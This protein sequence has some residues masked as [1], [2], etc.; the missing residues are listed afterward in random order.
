MNAV[1]SSM[2]LKSLETVLVST[3][4]L[5][6]SPRKKLPRKRK[7]QRRP[8][9]K[10]RRRQMGTEGREPLLSC[11]TLSLADAVCAVGVHM[12]VMDRNYHFNLVWYCDVLFLLRSWKP[13][14]V[15]GSDSETRFRASRLV[16]ILYLMPEEISDYPGLVWEHEGALT[17]LLLILKWQ[18]RISLFIRSAYP[19]L[20]YT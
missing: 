2:P 11:Y 5:M 15:A 12:Y 9:R 13:I 4:K 1:S 14:A 17:R 19:I 18:G 16:T 8:R 7:R 3:T 10:V 20:S 6:N